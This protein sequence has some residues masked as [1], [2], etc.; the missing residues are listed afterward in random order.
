M[1]LPV[2]IIIFFNNTFGD[3]FENL[4][5]FFLF[6]YFLFFCKKNDEFVCVCMFDVVSM[7]ATMGKQITLRPMFERCSGS[8]IYP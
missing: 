7:G 5:G 8:F 3:I 1:S 2:L 6:I 4:F